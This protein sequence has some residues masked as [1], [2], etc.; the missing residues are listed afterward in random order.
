MNLGFSEIG[1]VREKEEK[2]NK[3]SLLTNID[4]E[5]AMGKQLDYKLSSYYYNKIPQ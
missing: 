2:N 5:T 3:N 1:L 4:Q